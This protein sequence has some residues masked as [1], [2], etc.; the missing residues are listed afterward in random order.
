MPPQVP[1]RRVRPDGAALIDVNGARVDAGPA[2]AAA[3]EHATVSASILHRLHDLRH[4]RAIEP[5][6]AER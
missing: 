3:A 6:N 5:L 1:A 2:C 4:R